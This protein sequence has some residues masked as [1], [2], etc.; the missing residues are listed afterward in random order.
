VKPAVAAV[1]F[2]ARAQQAGGGWDYTDA[3]T[4]RNDLSITGWQVMAL[5]AALSAGLPVPEDALERVRRFLRSAVLPDGQ[6]VYADQGIGAGRR[7]INMTAVA[8]LSC[9]YLGASADDPWVITAADRII[10][11]PPDPDAVLEWDTRHQSSYYW[12]AAT[13]CLFNL[14]GERWD[15]WNHFLVKVVLPLQSRAVHEDGSW[16][17][18]GNWIG[19]M[20]GRV[21]TTAMNVLTLE[22]YYRY[23]PLHAYRREGGKG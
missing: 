18:D 14:G 13:L 17:P 15:A 4:G 3:R 16:A 12:Y 6:A 5:K 1:N 23:A 19:S 20:G 9:L 10:R 11:T 21:F 8:L 2:T 7:G 22:V